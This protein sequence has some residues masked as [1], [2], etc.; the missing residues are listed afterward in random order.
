MPSRQTYM[1]CSNCNVKEIGLWP[2]LEGR[3][4]IYLCGACAEAHGGELAA[5]RPVLG[6]EPSEEAKLANIEAL[7]VLRDDYK[8]KSAQMHAEAEKRRL[9]RLA[10]D[11][12]GL[13]RPE[14][15]Q[16]TLW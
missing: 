5:A 13:A 8:A 1:R 12:E 9:K 10:A 16:G 2:V 4:R 7:R 15:P 14:D 11:L 3:K 6:P